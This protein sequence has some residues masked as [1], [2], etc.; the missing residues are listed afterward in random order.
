MLEHDFYF[1]SKFGRWGIDT[2]YEDFFPW[3]F[4]YGFVTNEMAWNNLEKVQGVMDFSEAN[5]FRNLFLNWDIP[6]SG[7]I[8]IRNFYFI[9]NEFNIWMSFL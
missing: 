9:K 8:G 1:G 7:N 5:K 4:N 2:E 3:Y 6:Y